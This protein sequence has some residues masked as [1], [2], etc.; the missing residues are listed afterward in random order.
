MITGT[1]PTDQQIRRFCLIMFI[2]GLPFAWLCFSGF[3]DGSNDTLISRMQWFGTAIWLSWLV[4]SVIKSPPRWVCFVLWSCSLVWHLQFLPF[5]FAAVLHIFLF[6]LV[7]H[8]LSMAGLS[9]YLLIY[10]QASRSKLG[11]QDVAPNP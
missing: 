9:G 6:Y 1:I 5:A 4:R 2:L 11:E 10:D 8:A 7:V 3:L